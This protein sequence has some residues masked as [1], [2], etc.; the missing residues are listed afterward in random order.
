MESGSLNLPEPSG[1]HRPVMAMLMLSIEDGAG[2]GSRVD[3]DVLN[4]RNVPCILPKI[5]PRF[6]EFPKPNVVHNPY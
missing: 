5:E 3:M 6:L 2:V 1:S 4:N